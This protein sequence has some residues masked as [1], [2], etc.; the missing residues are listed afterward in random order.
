MYELIQAYLKSLFFFFFVCAIVTYNSLSVSF[1][2]RPCK[3]TVKNC[4]WWSLYH[5]SAL[6]RAL[7][8]QT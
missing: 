2:L 5:V 6:L 3:L 1:N 7:Q 4:D 8:R